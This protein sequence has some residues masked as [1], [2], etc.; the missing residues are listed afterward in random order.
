MR[1]GESI[2]LDYHA[3]TPVDPRV[4]EAMA[5]A[6]LV[7]FANPSSDDH[8]LGWRARGRIDDARLV[9][10]NAFGAAPEEM[11]FTSGATEA[12]NLAVLGAARA[13]PPGR[14][15]ILLGAIEHKA[16]LQAGSALKAEGYEVT[17]L[18]VLPDG[19]VDLSRLDDTDGAEVAVV[20]VMAVNNET[21][22]I[23][24][25]EEVAD[26]A[27][28][29]GAFSHCDA[30]QAPLAL[31]MDLQ[32]W[33]THAASLS[34]HKIYGPKG[35]GALY[36]AENRPWSPKPLVFGGGQEEGLRPG[37]VPTPLCVGFA[38]AA[39]IVTR[40]GAAERRSLAKM[41]DSFVASLK[42]L[43]AGL[44]LTAAQSPRHPGN[45]HVVFS[46]SDAADLLAL[47]QPTVAA[48]LGSACTSGV[49]GPSHVLTAMGVEDAEASRS[50]RFSLGRF[51]DDEQLL[52]VIGLIA[53][54]LKRQ[55]MRG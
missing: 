50:L 10:A 12:N 55:Q 25:F 27:E 35:V 18:A 13:A 45:A 40:E 28:R 48:S 5:E 52:E 26:W 8:A 36:L 30:T 33:G 54:A 6:T 23:Q 49:I 44:A 17:R 41:R 37:T 21:G 47:L 51:T 34:S 7:D 29:N 32:S 20:S 3:A 31:P 42:A 53:K 15:R 39:E 14:R 4:V 38:A 16:V 43:D 1:I 11:T 46:R 19:R 22:V 24:P 9:L 2:Y